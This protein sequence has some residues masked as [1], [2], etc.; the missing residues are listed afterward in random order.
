MMDLLFGLDGKE[1]KKATQ[2]IRC[3]LTFI[4]PKDNQKLYFCVD[5]RGEYCLCWIV[6]FEGDK[7]VFRISDKNVDT[8]EWK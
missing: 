3:D 8:I 7:E 2:F 1:I 6:C 4:E 5:Y